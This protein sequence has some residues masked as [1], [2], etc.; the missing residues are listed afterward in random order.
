MTMDLN[1]IHKEILFSTSIPVPRTLFVLNFRQLYCLRNALLP[2]PILLDFPTNIT[3]KQYSLT[4]KLGLTKL[5]L[6]KIVF[7]HF[8]ELLGSLITCC[9]WQ[10]VKPYFPGLSE[11]CNNSMPQRLL[12]NVVTLHR[13]RIEDSWCRIRAQKVSTTLFSFPLPGV[14]KFQKYIRVLKSI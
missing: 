4:S 1:P 11:I 10:S 2:I 13:E 8:C 5:N 12:Y 6:P 9:S 14:L 3:K 7:C